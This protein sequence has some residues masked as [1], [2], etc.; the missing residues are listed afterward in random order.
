MSTKNLTQWRRSVSFFSHDYFNNYFMYFFNKNPKKQ[1]I[2]Q[3]CY[4]AENHLQIV[5]TDFNEIFCRVTFSLTQ[6]FNINV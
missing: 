3:S 4:I 5:M 1:D 2:R 6:T